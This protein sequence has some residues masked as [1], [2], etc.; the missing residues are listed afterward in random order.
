MHK[1]VVGIPT[2]NNP[3]LLD[4]CISSIYSTHDMYKG[5]DIKVL[6]IDDYSNP[7]NL[8]KNKEICAAHGLDLLMNQER[9]G[10]PRC[11]NILTRHCQSDYTILINDDIIVRH[12]WIDTVL[13]TLENNEQIGVVGLNAF[14]GENYNRPENNVPT[15]VESKIL[16][17]GNLHPILSARGFAFGFRTKEFDIIGGF[18]ERY[19]CF[20]EEVDFNL[21]IMKVLNKRSCMLSHPI[22]HHKHGATTIKDLSNPTEVFLKSKALFEEKWC[23]EWDNIRKYITSDTIPVINAPLNEWN[24]NYNIWG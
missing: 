1:I 22:L 23:I 16:L 19:F 6:V 4:A 11:W 12:N 10:V 20:F 5:V 3:G 18:D 8:E 9:C 24:S 13:Y 17:G 21:S 7:D 14:E 15:Y 2:L